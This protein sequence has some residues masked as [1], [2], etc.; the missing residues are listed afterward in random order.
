MADKGP[1]SPWGPI[2][3]ETLKKLLLDES[4]ISREDMTR[5]ENLS[6]QRRLPLDEVMVEE[7]LITRELMGQ[8]IAEYY[9]V[10]FVDLRSHP[11]NRSDVLKIPEDMARKYH[12]VVASIAADT[13]TVATENPG[14]SNL[15]AVLKPYF[16]DEQIVFAYA[17]TDAVE[18]SF[19]H[20]RKSL[21]TRLRQ[22]LESGQ[23]VAPE[24]ISEL[25]D[26]AFTF[27]ASDIHIEPQEDNVVVRFR[28]DGVLHEAGRIPKQYYDGIV[29]RIK[30]L[31]AIRT[32]KHFDAQDGTIRWP[33]Q[34]DH[35]DVRVS[36]VPLINGEK[37]VMRLLTNYVKGLGL[38]DL[39]F[40]EAHQTQ[41]EETAKKPFGMLLVC[42][43][44][45]SGKTTTLYAVLKILN[46]P[47]VNITTIED[48]V[49][50]K[51]TGVNQIQVNEDTNLTFAKG[52]RSIVR[53]DP[54]I[55]FVGEIRDRETAEI[56]VNAALTGHLLLSSFHAN[57]A[58]TTIPRLLDMGVEPFLLASTL[59]LIISQRLV[60]RICDACRYSISATPKDL[61]RYL[62]KPKRFFE[63][64]TV[65][66][67]R[68]KG[69]PSCG[70]TGYKGRVAI[71][72][73]IAVTREMEGLILTRPSSDQI[74]QLAAKQGSLSLFR[75]GVDKVK[76]GLTSL[77]ELLRVAEIPED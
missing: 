68:G 72:E 25:F 35:V 37:V 33:Y 27:R 47:E 20:Y 70:N 42:G 18:L 69:C 31:A 26:D 60:R 7:E 65:D 57:D 61:E 63:E 64:K 44:T 67:Y 53:Q 50:Y 38:A 52:L 32:D 8:A 22:I 10:P 1:G 4:Y 77:E 2:D 66:L 21:A 73:F 6:R 11:P 34:D 30:V 24:I 29:N 74:W 36:I 9:R 51:L 12:V 43:P 48:P 59:E 23:K 58:T 28:I 76:K 49:E 45:G 71:F 5:V 56:A 54:N 17:P 14:L 46:Q 39:G 16:K 13:V 3:D 15:S 19:I 62:P 40:S 75:D 55:I 41:L